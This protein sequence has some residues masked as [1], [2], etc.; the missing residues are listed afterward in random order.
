MKARHCVTESDVRAVVVVGHSVENEVLDFKEEIVLKQHATPAKKATSAKDLATDIVAMANTYG[1]VILVG[2]KEGDVATGTYRVADGLVSVEHGEDIK[3]WL[4]NAVRSQISPR[5]LPYSVQPI[6]LTTGETVV[7]INIP[8]YEHLASI[9]SPAGPSIR[10]P[11]RTTHG[12][13]YFFPS[14]VEERILS[15]TRRVEI[16]LQNHVGDKNV[17]VTLGS[18][19]CF[20][21][22]ESEEER[23]DRLRLLQAQRRR[24][25]PQETH[26]Q[27]IYEQRINEEATIGGL[28]KEFFTLSILARKVAVPYGAVREIWMGMRQRIHVVLEPDV[29]MPYDIRQEAY[30]DFLHRWTPPRR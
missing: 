2:V 26:H 19:L 3:E 5:S 27:I 11:Y 17:H 18:Y 8:A 13:R 25:V 21:R 20:E 1:G 7:A 22:P 9:W 16:F 29:I 14:E 30:L 4:D 23:Q 12:N 28:E 15:N 6:L 24:L 10:Y